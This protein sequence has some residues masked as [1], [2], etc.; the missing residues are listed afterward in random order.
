MHLGERAKTEVRLSQLLC[1]CVLCGILVAAWWPFHAP[2]NQ[3]EWMT[4]ENGLSF[5][6]YGVV[7]SVGAFQKNISGDDG[8][9]SIEIWLEPRKIQGT[10]T[11]LAFDGS[12]HPG[13]PFTL[14]QTED[15]LRVQQHNIDPNNISWTA[16]SAVRSVFRLNTPIFITIVLSTHQTSVY[17]NG[18][19][20]KAFPISGASTRNLTGRLVIGNSPVAGGSWTGKIFGLAVYRTQLTPSQVAQ[21]YGE[22][23]TEHRP[24]LAGEPT[25]AALFLFNEGGGRVAHNQVDAVTDLQLPIRYSVLHPPFLEPPWRRYQFGWPRWSYWRDVLVNI[26]GFVPVGFFLLDHL[27]IARPVKHPVT[28][29]IFAGFC[30]SLTIECI[31]WYLPTRFSDITDIICNTSGTVLGVALYRLPKVRAAWNRISN[32]IV[33]IFVETPTTLDPCGKSPQV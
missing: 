1:I 14:L 12:E 11:I 29:V 6:R 4:G 19:L 23:T 25:P 18:V 33:S 27:L 15:A 26:G 5:G 22:W 3:V 13:T 24:E 7:L 32:S 2:A 10:Q 17:V 9:G 28:I 21:H 31:Q 8:S 30:L 20:S 16:D